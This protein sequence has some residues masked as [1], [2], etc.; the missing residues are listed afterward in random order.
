MILELKNI[1]KSFSDGASQKREVLKGVNL[2]AEK[3]DFIAITGVSGSGKTT[4]LN[5]LGTQLRPDSGEYIL[6]RQNLTLPGVEFNDIRNQKIGFVFQDFRLMPQFSVRENILLPVLAKKDKASEEDV[7]YAN[8]L[9]QMLGIAHLENQLPNTLSGGE[10][11]RTSICRALIN[12]PAIVLADEPTGQLDVD[13]A[14]RIATLLSDI[15]NNL[16]T[17][18]IMVTHD[19]AIAAKAKRTI[20]LEE[21]NH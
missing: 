5:I 14:A 6:D 7:K 10:K 1:H 21:I 11:A 19:P 9:M 13:N 8:E 18:I 15:S 12:H 3:G 20:K 16:G 17:T 4:L 2:A